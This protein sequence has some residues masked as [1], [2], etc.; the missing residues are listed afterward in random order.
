MT[1]PKCG[2]HARPAQ[3]H[4]I[5]HRASDL[6][7]LVPVKFREGLEVRRVGILDPLPMQHLAMGLHRSW[8]K[9]T[10]NSP[11]AIHHPLPGRRNRLL[12]DDG[13]LCSY[14]IVDGIRAVG[15]AT[16]GKAPWSFEM[17]LADGTTSDAGRGPRW[18]VSSIFVV[19]GRRHSGVA[20]RL[21]V[22][23]AAGLGVQVAELCWQLPFTADGAAFISGLSGPTV[24][25]AR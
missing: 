24:Y 5:N 4:R 23:L 9:E 7:V 12:V 8:G 10:G 15:S 14:V 18:V 1:C 17:H 25:V 11:N 3:Q 6:G 21:V 20:R 2:Y 22:G 16:I 19:R 13:G